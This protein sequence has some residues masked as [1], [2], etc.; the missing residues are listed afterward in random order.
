[1]WENVWTPLMVKSDGWLSVLNF[2]SIEANELLSRSNSRHWAT[3]PR[4]GVHSPSLPLHVVQ[5]YAACFPGTVSIDVCIRPTSSLTNGSTFHDRLP[6][7]Q[8]SWVKSNHRSSYLS[9]YPIPTSYPCIYECIYP[10]T[11]HGTSIIYSSVCQPISLSAY[12]SIDLSIYRCAHANANMFATQA[13][14]Q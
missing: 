14:T 4:Y 6:V 13:A 5:T 2:Q 12:Q 3:P 7:V 10:S 1:M 11:Q 9:E 8:G